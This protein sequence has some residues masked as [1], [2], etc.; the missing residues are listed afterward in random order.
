MEQFSTYNMLAQW[1][2]PFVMMPFLNKL[3]TIYRR[4]N[5]R[6]FFCGITD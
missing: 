3:I 1:R 6:N 2:L 5:K 4:Q